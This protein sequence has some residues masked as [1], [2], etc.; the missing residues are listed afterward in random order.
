MVA[1][2]STVCRLLGRLVEDR[3]EVLGEAHVEHLVGLVEHDGGDVAQLQAAAVEQVERPARAWRRRRRRRT[4]A[5]AAAGRS[6]R[7]R[8]PAARGRRGPCR[9]GAA[10][11]TPGRRAR[12][13][14]P[15]RAPTGGAL[16]AVRGQPLQQRQREGG[17]LAGAGGGLPEQVAALEQRRD[18]LP[19][20]RA[21][22]PRSRGRSARAS[23]SGRRPRSSKVGPSRAGVSFAVHRRPSFPG[24]AL[25]R[26]GGGVTGSTR[27]RRPLLPAGDGARRAAARAG[28]LRARAARR[29]PGPDRPAEPRRQRRR[30][31]RRRRRA[32]GRR[33]R[34]RGPGGG[35]GRRPAARPAGRAQGHPRH[36]RHADDVGLAAARRHGAAARR[37]GRGAVQGGRRGPGRAR[38]TCRSSRPA[39]T[40]STRSSARPTTRTGTACR[41][42]A[43]RAGRRRRWPRASCRSPRAATW[44]ARCATRPR[45]ATSSACVPR[46][47]RVP[48]WPRRWAGRSCR[49]R[50]RWAGRSPTSRCSCRCW[51]ARTRRV[52][53]SLSDDPAGVRRSPAR[54]RWTGCGWRGRRTSAAG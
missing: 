24:A 18:R 11:R 31:P 26:A 25:P 39:R 47:G 49:C 42:A 44:A 46:P 32:G 28:D 52:P 43:R 5:R 10:P 20:D 2:N 4:P 21:S 29:A 33:R 22:A 19:L 15:G 45:S 1:E 51:P 23:S 37:A 40:R 7:R 30:H 12:G 41:R 48:T 35:G 50:G 54:A 14:A 16:A 36:R 6:A 3:L 17:G 38:P 13:W 53:I 27:D 34:R 8:R 9:S